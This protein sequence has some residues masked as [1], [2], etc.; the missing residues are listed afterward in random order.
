MRP[1]KFGNKETDGQVYTALV[2]NDDYITCAVSSISTVRRYAGAYMRSIC[3][4]TASMFITFRPKST[5]IHICNF[6]TKQHKCHMKTQTKA[7]PV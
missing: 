6:S 5:F 3:V 4:L 7:C 2:S 1:L